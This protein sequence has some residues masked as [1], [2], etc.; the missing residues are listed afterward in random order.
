MVRNKKAAAS[1]VPCALGNSVESVAGFV[2]HRNAQVTND[3]YIAMSRAQRRQM[4]DCPWLRDVHGAGG[5]AG[6]T[7]REQG[8]AMAEAICSPFGSEDGRTFPTLRFSNSNHHPSSPAASGETSN[9]TKRGHHQRRKKLLALVQQCL[10][11]D[12]DVPPAHQ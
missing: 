6:P 8:R 9:N 4:V 3:V 10:A 1:R 7:L 12:E 2:G 5:A 11:E